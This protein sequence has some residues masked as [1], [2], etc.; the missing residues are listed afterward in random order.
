MV[1]CQVHKHEDLRSD[2]W[3]PCI[4]QTCPCIS[5]TLMLGDGRQSAPRS[6]LVNWSTDQPS[7]GLSERPCSKMEAW[8]PQRKTLGIKL[9]LHMHAHPHSTQAHW[10]LQHSTH[11]QLLMLQGYGRDIYLIPQLSDNEN[12]FPII[13]GAMLNSSIF[14]FYPAT[15]A[16]QVFNGM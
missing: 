10:V 5:V 1:K 15:L 13:A 16:K 3:H 6:L 9:S 2:P 7:S 4:G 12:E 14:L 11:I 8:N